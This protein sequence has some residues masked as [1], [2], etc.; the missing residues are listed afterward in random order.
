VKELLADNPKSFN[1]AYYDVK[2]G[3]S[4]KGKS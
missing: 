2:K 3:V 1:Y 4:A